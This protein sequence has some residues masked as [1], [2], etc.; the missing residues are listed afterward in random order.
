[1]RL[2][3][4]G[5][6]KPMT[7]NEERDS[8][9]FIANT[10]KQYIDNYGFHYL[11][12]IS[13]GASGI[14]N[15]AIEIAKGLDVNTMEYL[16]DDENWIGYKKRNLQIADECDRLICITVKRRNDKEQMCYHH[17]PHQDHRKTAGC[18]TMRKAEELGRPVELVII[19]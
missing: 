16:P 18:W 19:D 2:A 7:E 15:I 8:R 1:M 3:I 14:D 10:I 13:G 11:E 12:I 6:S 5:T 4:V 9:Q 17:N